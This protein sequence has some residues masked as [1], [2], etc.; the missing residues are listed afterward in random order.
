MAELKREHP[1]VAAEFSG[2]KTSLVQ[3]LIQAPSEQR[4]GVLQEYLRNAVAETVRL[5]PAQ[6][7][8]EAGFFDLGMDSL[9]AIEL[10]Q[11]LKRIWGDQFRRP[12]PLT[13]RA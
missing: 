13:I 11:R 6:I 12:S 9:M 3:R 8:D 10:R 5:D 1:A 2:E 4:R 7:R